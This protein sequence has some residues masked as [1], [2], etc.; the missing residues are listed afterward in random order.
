MLMKWNT[1]VEEHMDKTLVA[2]YDNFEHARMAVEDLVN[3]GFSRD[4]IS[5]IANDASGEYRKY[6]ESQ[7]GTVPDDVK[8]GEGASMGAVIGGLLGL[9]LTLIPG[10]GPVLAAGP[11]AS[12]LLGGAIGATTGAATGGITAA[13]VDMGINED[14]A[15]SY[16][17]TV[18]RGGALISI[19]APENDESHI[20]DILNRHGAIDI[21]KRSA[22]YRSTGWKGYDPN[23]QPYTADQIAE[24]RHRYRQFETDYDAK[25]ANLKTYPEYDTYIPRFQTHY[26]TNFAN[27][28][29]PYNRY[30][31]AYRYGYNLAT[32]ERYG[33]MSDWDELEPDARRLWEDRNKNTWDEFKDA[34][35]NAW[36]EVKSAVT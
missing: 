23:S 10:I 25:Y 20:R 11:L 33:N 19:T 35:R 7:T 29:Y 16:T 18:R 13:L 3:A 4:N 5:L 15:A 24:E 2:L 21:N 22:Y 9:G 36:Q 27:S 32:S 14:T 30:E 1:C 26:K 8:A 17:E 12:A 31:P 28:G 34:V 6:F